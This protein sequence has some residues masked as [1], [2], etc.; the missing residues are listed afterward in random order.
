MIGKKRSG[1]RADVSQKKK[2]Q[3]FFFSVRKNQHEMQKKSKKLGQRR[4]DNENLVTMKNKH[5]EIKRKIE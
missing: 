4:N 1:C 3:L 2:R 5:K